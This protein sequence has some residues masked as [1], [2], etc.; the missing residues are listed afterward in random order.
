MTITPLFSFR[1]IIPRWRDSKTSLI[2]G[3]LSSP[4]SSPRRK[5]NGED[6]FTQKLETWNSHKEIEYAAEVVSAAISQEKCKDAVDAANYIIAKSEKTTPSVLSIANSVLIR[7]EGKVLDK[8]DVPQFYSEDRM[9]LYKRIHYL[10]SLLNTYPNNP[11]M[12][13]DLA[14]AYVI[15]GQLKQS[16]DTMLIANNLAPDNRFI[17]RSATRL[18]VHLDEPDLAHD[19]LVK[20]DIT[21][22]EPWLIAAEI[23]TANVASIK[24][25][26]I[27]QGKEILERKKFSPF[28]MAELASA[29]A[30]LELSSGSVRNARK[31]FQMSLIEPT[32]NSVAQSVWVRKDLPTLEINFALRKTP[33]DYEAQALNALFNLNWSEAVEASQLWFAD[34]AFSSR[35]AELGSYAASLGLENFMRAEHFSRIGLIANPDDLTLINNLAYSLAN[36]NKLN[37]AAKIIQN[38]PRISNNDAEEIALK[39]TEGLIYIRKGEIE[40]G[41][42]F[43][44]AAISRAWQTK[45]LEH[46][47]FASINFAREMLLAG[48]LTRN[49]AIAL[50]EKAS[51]Y[52]SHPHVHFLLNRF[53]ANS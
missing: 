17:L 21:K 29:I 32:E 18:F 12:W 41:K 22:S 40:K 26:F 20:R 49:D 11:L 7:A 30:T 31:L 4:Q 25:K 37:D 39:A 46:Y 33:R 19:L 13:A 1:R 52:T 27:R 51:S 28:H 23:A 43:Y 5:I 50:A 8:V 2:T 34:E 14:L 24:P 47:A 53:V 38:A 44:L 35:P 10:R 48:G 6:L 42:E 9:N 3:E 36:Q 15:V 16:R 45:K